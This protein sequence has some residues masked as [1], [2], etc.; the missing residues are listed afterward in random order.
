MFESPAA[1][2]PGSVLALVG[3]L[4]C[5]AATAPAVGM[6]AAEAFA[7][8]N[9]LFRDD[10]YWAALLR[11][12][13]AAEA[14]MDSPLL[15]Y[16]MGVAHYR[17][18]QHIR[19]R[20][21]LLEAAQ[22]PQLRV[23]S[24]YNL[25]LNAYA[26][27]DTDD[28]LA[29][30][31]QARDQ[32]QNHRIRRL[33]IEAIA[34][35][36]ARQRE[37]VPIEIRA[38]ATRKERAFTNLELKA[39]VGFGNDDNVFRS[40]DRDYVDLANPDLPLV[41]PEPVAGA[42]MPVDF[43]LRYS[44]NSL[45]FESFYGGYRL[46]GRYFQD[47]ELDNANEFSHEIRFGNE[48]ERRKGSRTRRVHS[49]FTIARHDE[50][51][52]D[53]DDGSARE[54]N[55]ESIDDRLNYL[56]YGP[57]IALR[58]AH[59]RLSVGLH[60]KGQLWDY[61]D[62]DAV[63]EYDHEFFEFG[64]NLQYRFTSTSLLRVGIEKRSRRYGDRPSFDLDGRQLI[65]NPAVHYDY[66][67]VGLTARQRITRR[68][69]FG[70]DYTRTDRTDRYVGYNDYVRDQFGFEFHWRIS[71]RFELD[72]DADYSVYD[73]PRAFAFHNPVA[74]PKTLETNH[75]RFRLEYR[76]TPRLSLNADADFREATSTDIRI[77]HTRMQ[78][79]LGVSWQQ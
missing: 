14:G 22:A 70:F 27:G 34:R 11:Y 43:G 75:G 16:N 10:L 78:F 30:F 23:I 38:S 20:E 15:H 44:I 74:G 58:Q 41:A 62:T 64:G 13:Q 53:P 31:R 21:S 8:G 36:R 18:K 9:R 6:T 45:R 63:P 65:D 76:L 46:S 72:F 71:D 48:F 40:P 50:T 29:W 5:L 17:A 54:V 2:R 51:Y 52:Y 79:A 49:A 73:F 67:E 66:L 35:I 55:G 26:A 77:G 19:A 68:M 32:E 42:F 61:E 24:H 12:R 57:Q 37:P 60:L 1:R 4:F 7:D 69:W 59:E 56:R 25:G 39:R 3:A 47:K 33:A 28:A